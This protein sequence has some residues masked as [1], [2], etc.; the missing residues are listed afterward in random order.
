MIKKKRPRKSAP[1]VP[2]NNEQADSLSYISSDEEFFNTFRN[3]S[4]SFESKTPDEIKKDIFT[5]NNDNSSS[6]TQNRDIQEETLNIICPSTDNSAAA[7]PIK[8]NPPP[9]RPNHYTGRATVSN[10]IRYD[11][12]GHWVTVDLKRKRCKLCQL[13]TDLRCS[14]CQVM[15]CVNK[16][17]NCFYQFHH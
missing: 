14:K 16:N 7:I 11:N 15:L 17:R 5:N 3:E 8:K 10:E 6:S 12:T 1:V 2:S 4:S 13:K 9:S